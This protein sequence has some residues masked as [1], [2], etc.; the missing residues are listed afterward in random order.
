VS[1]GG[2]ASCAWVPGA[3]GW[4]EALLLAPVALSEALLVR[5]RILMP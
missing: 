1:S 3:G 2:A 5:Q 4:A